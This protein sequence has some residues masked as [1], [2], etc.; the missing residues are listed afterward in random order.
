MHF[1]HRPQAKGATVVATSRATEANRMRKPRPSYVGDDH[2]S[3]LHRHVLLVLLIFLLTD[4]N[5]QRFGDP[6]VRV[7]VV[8][9]R[10]GGVLI[11]LV[12]SPP[13]DQ[14]QLARPALERPCRQVAVFISRRRRISRSSV[15][16]DGCGA[17]LGLLGR[18]GLGNLGRADQPVQVLVE[19]VARHVGR[20][21][22]LRQARVGEVQC[23]QKAALVR[24]SLGRDQLLELRP[25]SCINPERLRG[26]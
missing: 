10:V 25:R 21:K 24:A 14:P 5:V 8:K 3:D 22:V 20:E 9:E 26:V 6:P 23:T 11:A 1:E 19:R 4:A 17:P 12:Y 16:T 15:A 2:P 18:R 13:V 7:G